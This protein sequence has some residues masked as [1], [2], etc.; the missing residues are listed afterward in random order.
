LIERDH[1]QIKSTALG[2][3]FLNDLQALFLREQSRAIGTSELLN[4]VRIEP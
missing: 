2:R 1:L 4:L 3:R